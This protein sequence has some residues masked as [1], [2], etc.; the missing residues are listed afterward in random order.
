MRLS[1]WYLALARAPDRFPQSARTAARVNRGAMRGHA[2]ALNAPLPPNWSE[3]V[4]DDGTVFFRNHLT[5]AVNWS[6]PLDDHFRG[7][8][9]KLKVLHP[10]SPPRSQPA[11]LSYAAS[12]HV[13]RLCRQER[14]PR[15]VDIVRAKRGRCWAAR[16]AQLQQQRASER[17]RRG[18]APEE[19][20]DEDE[21]D[22][23]Y[24][25]HTDDDVRVRHPCR[26]AVACR[27]RIHSDPCAVLSVDGRQTAR[28][29]RVRRAPANRPC[30]DDV[31]RHDANEATE[32]E[33]TGEE[34]RLNLEGTRRDAAS[35]ASFF[36]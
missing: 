16:A 34:P 28:Q 36:G 17:A 3:D 30:G 35:D 12:S 19:D 14:G 25:S 7:L 13:P 15:R 1:L 6:H 22:D 8:I 24:S 23:D 18:D 29:S 27:A 20:E 2:Q 11:C 32:S 10:L 21:D 26:V 33:S 4:T 31:S 5:G 9:V